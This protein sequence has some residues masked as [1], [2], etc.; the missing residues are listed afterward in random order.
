MPHHRHDLPRGERGRRRGDAAPSPSIP[1]SPVPFGREAAEQVSAADGTVAES[2]ITG[3]DAGSPLRA[4]QRQLGDLQAELA[5]LETRL[6]GLDPASAE[7]TGTEARATAL[8]EQIR[9]LR[10]AG[11][12]Q[13]GGAGHDADRLPLRC[14]PLRPGTRVG[15]DPGR[16]RTGKRRERPCRPAHSLAH[17]DCPRALG[18]RRPPRLVGRARPAPPHDPAGRTARRLSALRAPT[19]RG[20][21]WARPA[22]CFDPRRN[23]RAPRPPHPSCLRPNALPSPPSAARAPSDTWGVAAALRCGTRV[24]ILGREVMARGDRD[25]RSGETNDVAPRL[26][27]RGSRCRWITPPGRSSSFWKPS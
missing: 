6:R 16:D 24:N 5:R 25:S 13:A 18:D 17:P 3:E 22:R 2:N 9:A 19:G 8:R 4:N 1:P 20:R 23:D 7:K 10:E 14:R 11:N 26:A 21:G 27:G 15:P 12:S